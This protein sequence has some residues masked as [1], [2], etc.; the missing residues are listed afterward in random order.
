MSYETFFEF[1]AT[2]GKVTFAEN[3]FRVPNSVGN[4]NAFIAALIWLSVLRIVWRLV[5]L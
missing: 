4:F 5:F 2:P 3:L 1:I